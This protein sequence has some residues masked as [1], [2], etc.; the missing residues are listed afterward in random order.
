M[1]IQKIFSASAPQPIGP[2][3]QAIQVDK[4]IF[5]S[6][7]IA[8]DPQSGDLVEGDVGTQTK[9][10]IENLK[11]VLES[12]GSSLAKVVKTTIYLK[13]M[14]DFARVNEV[15][16]SYFAQSLPARSTVEVARLPKD[17]FVEIDCI[18]SLD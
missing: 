6:G 5:A 12:A 18:A 7:Q 15:Y 14:D 2:Y 4:L 17:V 8:L 16:G 9:Q 13:N 10:V 3:S 1:S 11:A